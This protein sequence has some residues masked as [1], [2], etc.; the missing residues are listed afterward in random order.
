VQL[1][2]TGVFL[3]GGASRIPGLSNMLTEVL[4]V[5]VEYLNPF[6]KVACSGRQF[7]EEFVAAISSSAAVP[8]G[9]ALRNEV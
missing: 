2:I 6:N 8:L 1:P 4:G 7:N 3:C 5:T 9:L